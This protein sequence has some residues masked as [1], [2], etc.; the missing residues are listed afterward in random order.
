[1][2]GDLGVVENVSMT[3]SPAAPVLPAFCSTPIKFMNKLLHLL[4]IAL[5]LF[6][7]VTVHGQT[8]LWQ[9]SGNIGIGTMSPGS[10]LQVNGNLFVNSADDA[11]GG[12]Y[13]GGTSL[14]LLIGKYSTSP[15]PGQNSLY[16]GGNGFILDGTNTPGLAPVM[17]AARCHR[18][19]APFCDTPLLAAGSVH[20]G[21]YW[22]WDVEP[23][24]TSRP[25]CANASFD[26]NPVR[27]QRELS[28]YAG[29]AVRRGR[30]FDIWQ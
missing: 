25:E 16:V 3:A 29:N 19:E 14:G 23:C 24:L 1:L 7:V 18:G 28:H 9:D 17:A 11:V 22:Y 13:Y 20:Y 26:T 10:K 12:L 5:C 30:F 6:A 4:L 2:A 27:V 8:N 21:K 15:W